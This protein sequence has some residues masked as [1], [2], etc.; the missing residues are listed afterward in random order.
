MIHAS[1]QLPVSFV[2]SDDIAHG[3]SR[4]DP[5]KK[6]RSG[7]MIVCAFVRNAHVVEE[8]LRMGHSGIEK[9]NGIRRS[10]DHPCGAEKAAI[11]NGIKLMQW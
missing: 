7:Y 8:F 2:E 10:P 11:R 6:D 5:V 4:T 1:D 3:G 9:G